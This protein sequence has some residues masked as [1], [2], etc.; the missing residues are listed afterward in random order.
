MATVKHDSVCL[1]LFL[2]EH[3]KSDHVELVARRA[4]RSIVDVLELE[5]D[6]YETREFEKDWTCASFVARGC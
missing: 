1:A 3:G 2:H 6:S 5:G 4:V